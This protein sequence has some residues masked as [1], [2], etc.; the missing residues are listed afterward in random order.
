MIAFGVV[1][2]WEIS[3]GDSGLVE[4][5]ETLFQITMEYGEVGYLAFVVAI[6]L[7]AKGLFVFPRQKTFDKT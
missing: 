5:V 3:E 4:V 6:L 7:F 2:L 1:F